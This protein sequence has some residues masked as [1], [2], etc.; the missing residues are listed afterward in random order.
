MCLSDSELMDRC[1]TNQLLE[2]DR[3]FSYQFELDQLSGG[4]F[5]L[6]MNRPMFCPHCN[7]R[8]SWYGRRGILKCHSR[9]CGKFFRRK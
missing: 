9:R 1:E 2:Q 6:P 7:F 5:G 3:Q 4:L 8:A